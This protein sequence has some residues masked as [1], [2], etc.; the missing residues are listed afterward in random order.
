MHHVVGV[1]L[2]V[3][4]LTVVEEVDGVEERIAQAE[5]DGVDHVQQADGRGA[6]HEVS[7]YVGRVQRVLDHTHRRVKEICGVK[8][9]NIQEMML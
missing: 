2:A 6:D 9:E 3:V 7:Q 4:T 1:L 8:R 5:H